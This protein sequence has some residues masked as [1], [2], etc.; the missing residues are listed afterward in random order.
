[1]YACELRNT[2]YAARIFFRGL[3]EFSSYCKNNCFYCGIR[4]CNQN[5]V[6]YRI[7]EEEILETCNKGYNIGFRTFVLQSGEDP[8]FTKN[9]LCT[10]V[11]KIKSRFPNCAVTLSV[12]ELNYNTYKSLYNA[13]AERYLLRHETASEMHYQ[14][15]HPP[16]L[17]LIN[18]KECLYHLKDIG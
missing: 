8:Y 4:R 14:M 10:L 2:Y 5:A 11:Y 7:L 16:E 6:R 3:I 12:G 18:R 15:L 17:S 9:R 13:G 1:M